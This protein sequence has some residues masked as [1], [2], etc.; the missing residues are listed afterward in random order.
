MT[1]LVGAEQ[2]FRIALRVDMETMQ[3]HIAQT[4]IFFWTTCF[5]IKGV[6]INN[7]ASIKNCPGV[8]GRSNKLP[9]SF[10]FCGK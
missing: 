10:C 6:P 9:G 2:F 7:L 5:R 1:D 8:Q 3:F 4:D